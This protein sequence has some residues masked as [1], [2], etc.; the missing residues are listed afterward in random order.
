M[1][2]LRFMPGKP[3]KRGVQSLIIAFGLSLSAMAA[4]PAYAEI[5]IP[6]IKPPAP[7]A[8]QFLSDKDAKRFK[9]GVS[10]AKRGRWTEL[11]Q[12]I[13]SL[14]DPIA[15]DTLRWLRAARNP[16]VS[17][18]DITRVVHRQSDWPRMTSIRA[19]AEKILFDDP[20]SA[21]KTCLLYTSPSP[22]D[23]TLSRMPS[24]A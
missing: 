14:N 2:I 12:S 1:E 3:V 16:N 5:P 19:K 22:R 13:R 10:A 18:D 23:A 4:S 15:A 7:N 11:N 17:F 24:S 21:Q 9:K 6:R 8:S 20:I